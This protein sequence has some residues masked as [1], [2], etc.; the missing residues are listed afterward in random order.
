MSSDQPESFSPLLIQHILGG[1][2]FVKIEEILSKIKFK[3]LGLKFSGLP[4][5]FW[6][7]FEHM[8]IAQ[9]DILE[10]S[11]SSNYKELSWPEEYWP[12]NDLP[13]SPEHWIN[14]QKDFF[15]DR[16]KFNA[17]LL[18]NT[19]SLLHPFPYGTGQT[20]FREALLILEHNAY[21]TGQLMI[22][23]RMLEAES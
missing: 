21:H 5:S 10:F 17:F 16:E 18:N 19:K 9:K 2:A 6:Q 14:T 15:D 22:I 23:L 7:V 13:D 12:T 3:E 4:Y 11:T 8:R 1:N 20:L